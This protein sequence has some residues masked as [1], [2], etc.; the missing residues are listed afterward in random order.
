MAA[1]CKPVRHRYV[2]FSEQCI[3]GGKKITFKPDLSF[4][5]QSALRARGEKNITGTKLGIL[6]IEFF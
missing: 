6:L 5:S 4:L 3:W 1:G 2:L